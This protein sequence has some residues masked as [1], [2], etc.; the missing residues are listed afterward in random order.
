MKD[1]RSNDNSYVDNL[2]SF[3]KDN[4][5]ETNIKTLGLID[6]DDVLCLMEESLAVVNPSLFEGWSSIVEE[7]KSI[8]KRVV[9]SNIPVHVE[10]N[11]K[12]SFYFDP[13]NTLEL[14]NVLEKIWSLKDEE[15]Y[16]CDSTL[17]QRTLEFG[18][19]YSNIVCDLVQIE[20]DL[21]VD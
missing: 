6:Y 14:S 5:L 9:L 20:K 1:F 19:K 11:P 15:F 16:S 7:S 21:F 8:G 4:N 3:I 2:L 17:N 18:Q 13:K 10:Q 12:N